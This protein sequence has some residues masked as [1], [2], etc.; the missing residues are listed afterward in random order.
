MRQEAIQPTPERL[1][2]G[3]V[4]TYTPREFVPGAAGQPGKVRELPTVSRSRLAPETLWTLH[5]RGSINRDELRA[6]REL[7]EAYER[8]TRELGAINLD[9]M[10]GG[11]NGGLSH[12]RCSAMDTLHRMWDALPELNRPAIWHVLI[13]ICGHRQT[14]REYA[15]GGRP[16][17]RASGLFYIGIAAIGRV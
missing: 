6:G 4:E 17:M 9:S 5:S 14:L 16:M 3:D 2:K 15:G 1:A 13:A 10:G 12:S 11:W 7:G 8:A